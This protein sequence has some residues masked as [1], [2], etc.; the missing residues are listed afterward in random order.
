M[1][2]YTYALHIRFPISSFHTAL[3]YQILSSLLFQ[4][5]YGIHVWRIPWPSRAGIPLYY[6]NSLVLLELLHGARSCIKIYISSVRPQRIHMNL[7]LAVITIDAIV[8]FGANRMKYN[9]KCFQTTVK[10]PVSVQVWG[11]V[12]SIGLSL[13]RKMNGNMECA[14]Y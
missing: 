7:Y 4:W 8:V 5:S 9:D 10:S 14:K 3:G 12:S 13:L 6:R 1:L 11:A 2:H